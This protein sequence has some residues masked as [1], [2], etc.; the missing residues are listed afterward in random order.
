MIAE[1][2]TRV[3]APRQAISIKAIVVAFSILTVGIGATIAAVIFGSSASLSP[4]ETELIPL[5][6]RHNAVV[7]EWN[8]FLIEYNGISLADPEAFDA[9]AVDALELVARLA[10]NSQGVILAWDKVQAPPEMDAA[11]RFARDAMRLTQ[12][13]FIELGTYFSN[14]VKYGIA[15]DDELKAGTSRLEA[16]SV[17]W[18]QARSAAE[19]AE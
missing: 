13:G 11:H 6:A 19:S 12:D 1:T 10:T 14:I 2:I 3:E 7:G 16:A 18:S 8:E 9:R 15:F 5:V 4:Y 17:V